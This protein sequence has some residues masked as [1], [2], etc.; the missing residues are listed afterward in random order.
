VVLRVYIYISLWLVMCI[1]GHHGFI[2][3]NSSFIAGFTVDYLILVT[4]LYT[5]N[6]RFF[7][8]TLTEFEI[9]RLPSTVYR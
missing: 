9:R 4:E 5:A 8:F 1:A 2:V 7:Y 3:L 6:E